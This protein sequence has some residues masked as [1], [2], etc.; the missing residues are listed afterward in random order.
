MGLGSASRL[1]IAM[2]AVHFS[3]DLVPLPYAAEPHHLSLVEG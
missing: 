1:H 3:V 2:M